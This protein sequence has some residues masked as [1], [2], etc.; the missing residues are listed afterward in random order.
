MPKLGYV[1]EPG[2]INL[3]YSRSKTLHECPRK[4]QLKEKYATGVRTGNVH[5]AFGHAY[6]AMVQ[7]YFQTLDFERSIVAGAAAW[8]LPDLW[9]EPPAKS[10]KCFEE[11][12]IAF[13]CFIHQIYPIYFEGQWEIAKLDGLPAVELVYYLAIGDKFAQQGHID[14]ILQHVSD[15]S[16]CVWEIKTSERI[17]HP[18]QWSNS[19]QTETYTVLGDEIAHRYGLHNKYQVGYI[20]YNPKQ[21]E[22]AGHTVYHFPKPAT[23]KIDCINTILL[24]CTQIQSYEEAG[25]YPKNGDAC[26]NFYRACELYG[27]CDMKV[28]HNAEE[29][30]TAYETLALKD[31]DIYVQIQDLQAL[32]PEYGTYPQIIEAENIP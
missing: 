10:A 27:V 30:G 3:S 29:Q 28:L 15:G 21:E 20:I 24:E 11:V 17:T 4:F 31:V 16:L 2:V 18:A 22:N 8:D 26:Y 1:R 32:T 14:L 13:D 5:T 6:A 7:T 19:A 9:E 23:A 25:F 12:L